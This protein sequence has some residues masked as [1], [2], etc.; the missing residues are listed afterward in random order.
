MHE[1]D[2]LERRFF[3]ECTFKTLVE[4]D[5]NRE[6]RRAGLEV[7]RNPGRVYNPLVIRSRGPQCKTHLMHAIGHALRERDASAR[8]FW[9]SVER[10]CAA[11]HGKGNWERI[12]E[13]VWQRL[14][15]AT[16]VF[17]DDLAFLAG[18]ARRQTGFD[19]QEIVL[20]FMAALVD[21]GTA[22]VLAFN[23]GSPEVAKMEERIEALAPGGR[24]VT[25]GTPDQRTL[26]EVLAVHAAR[27]GVA[28]S[29]AMRTW[30]ARW[31]PPCPRVH[32]GALKR[33]RAHYGSAVDVPEEATR[34]VVEEMLSPPGSAR[35]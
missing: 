18:A 13:E 32:V 28:L 15:G 6:A 1:L 30:L 14:D 11:M 3:P 24:P 16:A 25:L 34:E 27:E 10:L 29:R 2:W 12:P 17:L 26:E 7:A 8:V 4:G 19:R 5:F 21:S 20:A 31:L 35:G 9:F 22:V 23:T 33:I